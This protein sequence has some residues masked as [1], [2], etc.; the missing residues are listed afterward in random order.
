MLLPDRLTLMQRVQDAARHR[1]LHFTAG[2][3]S[4]EKWPALSRK[5]NK[6]Y[7]T[8]LKKSTRSNRRR[9]G[10]AVALVYGCLSPPHKSPRVV[11]WVLLSTEGIGL[12]HG[13]ERLWH[14]Q[15]TRLELDGYEL[16]H[17]GVSWTWR[18]TKKRYQYWRD[19]IHAIAA[20]HPERRTIGED[21]AG[22]YDADIEAIQDALYNAPGFRLV[23]RQ[24]GELVQFLRMEWR[25]LR[26]NTSLQPRVRTF[27]P[28]VQRLSNKQKAK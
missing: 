5:F 16:V 22:K 11:S 23:R 24:V 26:P 17:D 13:L 21:A 4:P 1:Y 6:L 25:R 14:M 12:I 20:L 8:D 18:M 27:L 28:Y 9:R 10:E 3:T 15:G 7:S 19:R 2:Q